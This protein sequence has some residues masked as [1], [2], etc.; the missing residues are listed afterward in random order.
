MRL[1]TGRLAATVVLTVMAVTGCAG[2]SGTVPA[3]TPAPAGYAPVTITDCHGHQ[4][5][6]TAAPQRAVTL[7]PSV[8]EMMGWLGLLDRLV[9]VGS[10]PIPG[11]MPPAFDAEMQRLP[12][13]SGRYTPGSYKPVPREQLL[14][15]QPE[16]VLGAFASNFAPGSPGT[17]DDLARSGIS[18]YFALSNA[19]PS[20]TPG[21]DFALLAQDLR[22]IAAIFGVAE[23]AEQLIHRMRTTTAELSTALAGAT[24]PRVFMFEFDEGV[25]TPMAAGRTQ[26]VHSLIEMAGGRNI[27][28]DLAQPYRNVS[29]E[30]VAERDPEAMLVVI[31]DRGNAADNDAAWARAE[32][33]LRE[34]PLLRGT[35]AM[36]ANRPFIRALYEQVCQAGVRNADAVQMIARHL[37]PDRFR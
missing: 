7:T 10:P 36:R 16:V 3:T 12:A 22:N 26:N 5:T 18:S 8:A 32:T 19:C 17:Q 15:V 24:R 33:Y 20:Q 4:S 11:T 25:P 1:G 27:F 34:H 23:R 28:A 37:H 2:P 35:A 9:G 29:W 31:Y 14:A 6:F 13:L 30:A 21:S